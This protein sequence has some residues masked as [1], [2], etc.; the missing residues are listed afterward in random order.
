MRLQQRLALQY[1]RT[2]FTLLSSISKKKAAGKAFDLF[3]TPQYRNKKKLPPI[4]EKSEKVD[5]SL[6]GSQIHGYRWNHPSDKR[7]LILHGFESSVINFDRYIKPLIT[8]G[9]EILAFDAPAHGR[10][11]GKK[12][13]VVTYK[14]LIKYI[15]SNYGPIQ[16]F[17]AHSLGGLALGMALEEWQH[18]ES[19]KVVFIAPAVESTTAI[20]S[21]F[22]FLKLGSLVRR[23]F[24][25]LLKIKSGHEPEWFSISRTAP[26]LKA[27][28]LWM[29][30]KDDLMTPLKD[31][32]PIM[33]KNLPNFHFIISEGLGHRRIYRDNKTFKAILAF[34]STTDIQ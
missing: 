21:F 10:S 11:S 19:Y 29:Q 4:F 1:I 18:D 12:I 26:L 14:D 7:L 8:Q 33:N 3:C 25:L 23:E 16:N 15:L 9:F 2:K 24:D 34:F 6:G 20:D 5:F 32:V 13:T 31:V 17:I 22:K 27:K 28:V 30:D